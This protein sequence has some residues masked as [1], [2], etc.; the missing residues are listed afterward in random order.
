MRFEANM[1]GQAVAIHYGTN[2]M[3]AV[4]GLWVEWANGGHADNLTPAEE[5]AAWS[6]AQNFQAEQAVYAAITPPTGRDE[7]MHAE[8]AHLVEG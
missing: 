6:L 3:G 4:A 5:L 2:P 8:L 7:L 1:R